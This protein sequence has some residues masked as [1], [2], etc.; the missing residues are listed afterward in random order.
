MKSLGLVKKRFDEPVE[1]FYGPPKPPVKGTLLKIE[2]L[3]EK[4]FPVKQHD[5]EEMYS[6]GLKKIV[7]LQS[8]EEMK[9]ELKKNPLQ[10]G[11]SI[12]EW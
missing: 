4:Q 12:D 10:F 2:K 9:E 11:Y 1:K 3:N 5:I 8:Y 7:S 6:R